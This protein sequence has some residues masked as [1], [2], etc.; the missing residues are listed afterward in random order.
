MK[1]ILLLFSIFVFLGLGSSYAGNHEK[2]DLNKAS[3]G[4]LVE[5]KGIGPAKARNIVE[6]REEFGPFES[7]N[8][9]VNVKGFGVKT[10]EKMK[11]FL[12]VSPPE[13]EKEA[14]ATE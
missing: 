10:V 9:L 1:K 14:S 3:M 11:A 8:D 12:T 4:Q 13:E 2:L 5:I 7:I 6:Y